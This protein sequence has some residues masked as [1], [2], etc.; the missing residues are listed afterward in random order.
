VSTL[1]VFRYFDTLLTEITS[2]ARAAAGAAKRTQQ[3]SS[4]GVDWSKFLSKPSNFDHR[5]Q[6]ED[7]KRFKAWNWQVMQ[8]LSAIHQGYPQTQQGQW[9]CSKTN[10]KGQKQQDAWSSCRTT[11]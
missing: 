9:T 5:N 4:Q 3:G 1:P 6:E 11:L 2:A 7:I 8:H 10:N